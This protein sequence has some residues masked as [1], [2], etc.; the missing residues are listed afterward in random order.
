LLFDHFFD[1]LKVVSGQ[2]ER[3]YD[4]DIL[5]VLT[6][7]EWHGNIRELKNF[8]E[9]LFFL[10]SETTITAQGASSILNRST[11]WNNTSQDKSTDK[12][13]LKVSMERF[14]RNFLKTNLDHCGGNISELAGMLRMDRGNLYKKLKKHGLL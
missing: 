3:D 7:A 5:S 9:R 8:A 6:T 13:Q 1:H 10:T 4:S 12:N 11:S 2:T 14:E